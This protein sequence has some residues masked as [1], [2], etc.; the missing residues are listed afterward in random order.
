MKK[1]IKLVVNG[2]EKELYVDVQNTLLEVLRDK[3]NLTGVKYGCGTGECGACT[4][5]INGEPD[6]ACLSLAVEADGKRIETIEG[7]ADQGNLHPI[8]DAFLDSAAIQCGFCTPG[9]VMQ[10]KALINENP[11]PDEDQVKDYIKGNL[12]RCGNYPNIVKAILDAAEK[13]KS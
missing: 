1:I 3:L 4:V 11:N 6:L 5:L 13:M 10:A 9:M 2:D 12:C 7:V 8:Q